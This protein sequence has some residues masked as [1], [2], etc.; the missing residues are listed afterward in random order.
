MARRLVAGPPWSAGAWRSASAFVRLGRPHFLT[1][2]FLMYGLGAAVA[3][4]LPGAPPLDGGSYLW[5]QGA[6]TAFQLMTHYGNDYFDQAADSANATPTRW[7]G[8]SRVLGAGAIPAAAAMIAAL[9]FAATGLTLS[10]GLL[11]RGS[12]VSAASLLLAGGLAW[13]YSAP[14][15]RLHSRGVGELTTAVV[16]TALTPFVGFTLQA[17]APEARAAGLPILAAT[18][19][20]TFALQFAML[21]AI[22]LPDAAGD[23]AVGKKTLVVRC[24]GAMAARLSCATLIAVYGAL[25]LLVRCD[26][27]PAV[28]L[29]AALPFPLAVWQFVRLATGAWRSPAAWEGIAFRGVA[30]LVATA[31]AQLC[32][33]VA[34]IVSG[35][36]YSR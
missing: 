26:V 30:L 14:P 7:S 18:L 33:Q 2:G 15:L 29:A 31:A 22:E 12:T 8:G 9:L 4:G 20:P 19:W 34:V 21:L 3:R 16:V 11:L 32:A 27:A 13:F 6:I 36:N 5:G 35:H 10:L 28:L 24:G 23:A 17:T 25:P 1:G